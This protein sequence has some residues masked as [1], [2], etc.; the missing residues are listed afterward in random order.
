MKLVSKIRVYE[1]RQR[2]LEDVL[3]YLGGKRVN[4]GERNYLRETQNTSSAS[5]RG[6]R[7]K[8]KQRRHVPR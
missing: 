4:W 3:E 8:K 2:E 6:D 5:A 1:R 7:L